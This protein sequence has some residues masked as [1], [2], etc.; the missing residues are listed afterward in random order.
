MVVTM[1]A[2]MANM[3][4]VLPPS[5]QNLHMYTMLENALPD[6]HNCDSCNLCAQPRAGVLRPDCAYVRLTS[7]H[8]PGRLNCIPPRSRRS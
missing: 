6:T 5:Q 3:A 4:A 7:R 2:H 8:R 1:N